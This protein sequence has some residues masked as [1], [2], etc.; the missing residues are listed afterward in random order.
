MLDDHKFDVLNQLSQESKSLWRI[1]NE[2][3]P[4]AREAGATEC[5]EFWERMAED[6]QQH[7]EKLTELLQTVME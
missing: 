5:I 6:K 1:Q 4:D 7:I 2:Y 3:L